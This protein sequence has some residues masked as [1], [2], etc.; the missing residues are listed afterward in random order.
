MSNFFAKNQ[1]IPAETQC[2]TGFFR[3]CDNVEEFHREFY[4]GK[5]FWLD[6]TK[7]PWSKDLIY[8]NDDFH[9]DFVIYNNELYVCINTNSGSIP[10]SNSDW[11][12][13]VP[14]I[15]G[16][17]FYPTV[18]E[19]GNLSWELYESQDLPTTMNIKGD[20]GDKGEPGDSASINNV[21]ASITNTTG[22][23]NVS[24]K[25][26]GTPLSRSFAFEFRNL[27]GD[28]GDKGDKGETGAKG[29]SGNGNFF[30]GREAPDS[31]LKGFL[32][33]IY[34]NMATGE[35]FKFHNGE[36]MLT[37]QFIMEASD[38]LPEWVDYD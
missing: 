31:D 23:P 22:I 33:D 26:T 21:T 6:P 36:W 11:T 24:V 7:Q 14:Q 9:Q 25:T 4:R 30:V 16:K 34:L 29:E 37:G 35:L 18:D 27:K 10:G 3:E 2:G 13:A 28:K 12:L 19:D 1:T 8:Y 32:N 20:K 38:I 5:S 17:A 15:E